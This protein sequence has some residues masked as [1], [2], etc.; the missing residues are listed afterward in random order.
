MPLVY[1][2]KEDIGDKHYEIAPGSYR[3]LKTRVQEVELFTHAVWGRMLF[4]NGMLQSTTFDEKVY[5]AALTATLPFSGRVLILGGGEGAT[6]R[7]VLHHTK[8][9]HVDMI[10]WDEGLVNY[11]K[12]YEGEWSKGA[13]Q[14]PRLHVRYMDIFEW[15]MTNTQTYDFC[16]VDLFDPEEFSKQD[17]AK[18]LIALRDCVKGG[19]VLNGGRMPYHDREKVEFEE[20]LRL[21]FQ[22]TDGWSLNWSSLLVPSF[23]SEWVFAT[24]IKTSNN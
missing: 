12:E 7:D 5:H 24:L 15:I 18:L 21:V 11:M 16:V 19:I 22:P 3:Y 9:T 2:E 6:A 4:L 8:V 23:C 1:V 17:W 13:F 20:A 14:D 10:D